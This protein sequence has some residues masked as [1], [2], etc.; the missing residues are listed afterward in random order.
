MKFLNLQLV[1]SMLQHVNQKLF[2]LRM[3]SKIKI[4]AKANH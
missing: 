2:H 1:K 3:S 4:L